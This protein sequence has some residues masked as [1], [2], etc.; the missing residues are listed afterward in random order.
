MKIAVIGAGA[1]GLTHCTAIH[2]T[3]GVSLAGISDPSDAA[4]EIAARFATRHHRDHRALIAA[5]RPDGAVIATPN[6]W[7]VPIAV[8]FLEAGIPV[9][10]EKPVANTSTEALALLETEART[11]VPVLVGHHRRHHP[12]VAKAHALVTQGALGRMVMANVSYNLMKPDS[13]FEADWRRRP[14]IGGPFLINAIHE[15]DLLRHVMGEI[16]TVQAMAANAV[17]GFAVEDTGAVLFRFASGALAA[18][19]VSDTASAPWSWD[20]ASGDVPRFPRHDVVSHRFS[21][22]EAALTLP[23]LELWRHD[24]ERSWTTPMR[25]EPVPCTPADPFL[26]QLGNFTEVIAGR[27]APLVSAREGVLDL[28]VMEALLGAARSRREEEVAT[29]V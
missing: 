29:A 28:A 20:L 25:A 27:A 18:L 16:V 8:D 10:V 4:A 5:E 13:Y 26:R 12:F 24:G 7:H 14:G 15:I 3:D 19:T 21:G 11:G 23:R 6:S 17:R 22:T 2:A 9:L 1:I